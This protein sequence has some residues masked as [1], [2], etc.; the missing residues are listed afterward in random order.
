MPSEGGIGGGGGGQY[1]WVSPI[2]PRKV[3]SVQLIARLKKLHLIQP[4]AAQ[5]GVRPRG[6][7]FPRYNFLLNQR[8]AKLNT[9]PPVLKK[10]PQYGSPL[11]TLIH[12]LRPDIQPPEAALGVRPEDIFRAREDLLRAQMQ[13]NMS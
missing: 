13:R 1:I 12:K 3:Q 10:P 11:E 6:A 2:A 5:L 9:R 4:P 8:L 7:V